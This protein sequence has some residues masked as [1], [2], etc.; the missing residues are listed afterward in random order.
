MRHFLWT[1]VFALIL[2]GCD[3]SQSG[4]SKEDVNKGE[5]K[6]TAAQTERA[7]DNTGI[8]ERDRAPKA[9]TAGE[10]GQRKDDV[11]ITADIRKRVVDTEMS[12]NA[13]NCK[14]ITQ[15]GKVTLRGPVNTQEEKDTIGRIATEVAGAGNVDNQLEI[16]HK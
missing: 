6:P 3:K 4:A 8:N 5:A 15:D 13:H 2:F 9:K 11:Q 7:P 12:T 14:I 10:Q 1:S 16:E